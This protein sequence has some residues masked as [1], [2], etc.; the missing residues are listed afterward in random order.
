MRTG[1][2]GLIV[3][4]V[5][6]AAAIAGRAAAEPQAGAEPAAESAA[7]PPA[8]AA[9]AAAPRP[10]PPAASVQAPRVKEGFMVIPSIGINWG[11]SGQGTG[12]GL[13]VGLL[14]GS[15]L[16]E[17]FS[18]N[19]GL[20]FDRVNEDAPDNSNLVFDLGLAPLIHFPQE[21]FEILAGPILGSFV[22]H[23]GSGSGSFE[24]D[25]WTYGWTVG[26][27]VGVV[28]PVGAKVSVGGLLNFL[29]RNPLKTCTTSMGT[30]A[31]FKDILPSE[32]VFALAAAAMF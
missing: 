15:R 30:D 27:N 26:A 2:E 32:K 21:K 7:A 23:S 19:L 3:G 17:R 13:R 31:C 8:P 22:Q 24:S 29:L 18:L 1:H 12:V 16:T 9:P 25:S 6:A 28:V 20:A 4:V 14:A 11:D 5:L 10:V